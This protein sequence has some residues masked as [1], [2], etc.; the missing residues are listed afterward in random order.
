[1]TTSYDDAK[2]WRDEVTRRG[3]TIEPSAAD[4]ENGPGPDD[5]IVWAMDDG[6]IRGAF[7]FGADPDTAGTGWLQNEEPVAIAAVRR[8]GVVVAD[9]FHD[10]TGRFP[11]D[12]WSYY[13]GHVWEEEEAALFVI[14]IQ[15]AEESR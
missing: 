11:V 14:P 8:R 7:D 4:P 15:P 12:P 3:W 1:V 10:E 2:E 13:L 6:V 5:L 9:L